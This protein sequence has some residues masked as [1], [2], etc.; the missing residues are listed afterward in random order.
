MA[1]IGGSVVAIEGSVV[2]MGESAVATGVGGGGHGRVSGG[3]REVV[4]TGGGVGGDHGEW[5]VTPEGW[6]G[7]GGSVV[8]MGALLVATRGSVVA[9]EG[10]RWSWGVPGGHG[11]GR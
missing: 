6:G 7:H 2:A 11:G 1:A 8:A 10:S 3:P 5:G 9:I 4:V